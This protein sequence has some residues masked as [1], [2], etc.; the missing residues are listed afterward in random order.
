MIGVYKAFEL[1]VVLHTQRF[2]TKP[3]NMLHRRKNDLCSDKSVG[4]SSLRI[5]FVGRDA[6][7]RHS[8]HMT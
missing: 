1:M 6:I 8:G 2:E 7:S 4:S 3:L 5:V